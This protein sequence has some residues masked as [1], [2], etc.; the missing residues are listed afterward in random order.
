M[1]LH[2]MVSAYVS[3]Q[4]SSCNQP[5]TR[6]SSS[7]LSVYEPMY[8]VCRDVCN[9]IML[10]QFLFSVLQSLITPPSLLCVHLI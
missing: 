5:L 10:S 7:R 1:D 3:L 2:G 4:Y 6:L 8:I 9:P